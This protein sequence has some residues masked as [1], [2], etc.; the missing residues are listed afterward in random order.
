MELIAQFP[1]GVLFSSNIPILLGT[2][3]QGHFFKNTT[4]EKER[5]R[6]TTQWKIT[7]KNVILI[8][9]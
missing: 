7:W 5:K 2:K 4:A 9:L 1:L 3:I 6:G 8:T